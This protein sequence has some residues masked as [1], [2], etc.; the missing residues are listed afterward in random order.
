MHNNSKLFFQE[1]A[2]PFF[3]D[4][5][6]VLE[7]GPDE[8]PSTYQKLVSVRLSR[9]DYLDIDDRSMT[10]VAISDCEFPTESATFD[11][12]FSGQVIE[13]VRKPWLW[14]REAAR[15][16]KD[17]GL[18]ITISPINWEYHEAPIDCWRIYPEG[19]RALYEEAGLDMIICKEGS[20]DDQRHECSATGVS[21]RKGLKAER[22]TLPIDLIA[23]GKKPDHRLW[24]P[25]ECGGCSNM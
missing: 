1:Y 3:T 2:L 14:L 20:L 13:H 9:W 11:V 10:Y 17:G 12:V 18:V 19:M 22:S 23:I 16:C 15:V 21:G 24:R 5:M 7:I 8:V 4:G 25:D 6:H